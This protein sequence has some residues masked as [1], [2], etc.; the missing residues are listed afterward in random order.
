[1]TAFAV[2]GIENVTVYED[3]CTVEFKSGVAAD[4]ER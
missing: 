4:V 1:M 2:R 3:K